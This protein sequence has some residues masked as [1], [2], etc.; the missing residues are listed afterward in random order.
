[1]A[2]KSETAGDK[3]LREGGD[4]IRVAAPL[5]LFYFILFYF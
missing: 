5:A 4:M 3:V 1:M 2:E